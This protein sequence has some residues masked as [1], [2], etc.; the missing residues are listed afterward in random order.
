MLDNLR[1]SGSDVELLVATRNAGKLREIRDLLAG[2]GIAVYGLADFPDLPEVV[3]DGDTFQANAI[4]K[5][6]QIAQA[7]GKT[8]LADDSGLEVEALGGAPG[9]YSARYAGDDADD[10]ANNRK[11][12]SELKGIDPENRR[13]AF[14]CAMALVTSHGE[15]H[16]VCGRVEGVV[17]EHNQ[18]EGGF[19]YDPLFWLPDHQQSMAQIP[20]HEKNRI[21]HRGQALSRMLPILRRL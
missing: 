18:G 3:E 14:C 21:S 17:L 11:L 4:K 1:R 12:L 16:E 2:E 9:V 19:G 5:A 20:L 6:R 8:T 10:A 15:I 7:T 13:A